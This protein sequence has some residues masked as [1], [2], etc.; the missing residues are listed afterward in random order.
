VTNNQPGD[1]FNPKIQQELLNHL[2]VGRESDCWQYKS[3]E[4][5]TE[6]SG[7]SARAA[8]TYYRL[9]APVFGGTQSNC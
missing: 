3:A 6:F 1:K 5:H 4:H 2:I 9:H 8:R 7:W